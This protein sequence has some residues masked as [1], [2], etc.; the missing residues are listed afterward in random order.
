[1]HVVVHRDV[2]L[3]FA[4]I[5]DGNF[6]SDEHVLA[7]GDVFADSGPAA[8][9]HEVPYA[10]TITY[11]GSFVYD[12]TGVDTYGHKNSFSCHETHQNDTKRKLTGH[13]HSQTLTDKKL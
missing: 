12:G 7:H 9:V 3:D 10:G 2:V 1:M 8:Y 6:I 5:A 13:G 11:L 4:V